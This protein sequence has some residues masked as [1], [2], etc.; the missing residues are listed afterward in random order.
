M[1][2]KGLPKQLL[3]A[4]AD[5]PMTRT[6]LDRMFGNST[7]LALRTLSARHL[8]ETLEFR[9]GSEDSVKTMFVITS[10]GREHTRP[11]PE[12]CSSC[13]CTPCDCGY[14]NY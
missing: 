8:I 4:I 9:G 10:L 6:D 3:D 13:G 7:K 2:I 14:G 1:K 5:K 11:N 12:F